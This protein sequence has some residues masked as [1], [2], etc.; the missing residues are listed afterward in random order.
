MLRI[1][2]S[3][4]HRS[5]TSLVNPP[6]FPS[7]ALITGLNG[8][9]KSHLFEAME[10]GFVTCSIDGNNIPISKIRRFNWESLH[11]GQNAP[12]DPFHR[13][14]LFSS[15]WTQLQEFRKQN[16][17]ALRQAWTQ[18]GR[19]HNCLSVEALFRRSGES[20]LFENTD[21]RRVLD[22][23]SNET[24]TQL[25]QYTTNNLPWVNRLEPQALDGPGSEKLAV[26]SQTE[27]LGWAQQPNTALDPFK[28][29]LNAIF[30]T[31]RRLQRDNYA[32]QRDPSPTRPPLEDVD[33]VQIHGEPPWTVVNR[34]LETSNYPFRFTVPPGEGTV[35]VQIEAVNARGSWTFNDLSSGE[36]ILIAF[37]LA[38]YSIQGTTLRV[39]MPRLI[40]LDEVDAPLHPSMIVETLRAVQALVKEKGAYCLMT[41]H[42]PV[43]IAISE[44]TPIFRVNREEPRIVPT[45]TDEAIQFLTA[46]LPLLTVRSESRRSVWVESEK[47]VSRLERLQANAPAILTGPFAPMYQPVGFTPLGH[48]DEQSAGIHR[49]K[50][51]VRGLRSAGVVNAFGLV[52]RDASVSNADGLVTIGGNERYAVENFLL[53]PLLIALLIV[54]QQPNCA[55]SRSSL[56]LSE[57]RTWGG[58]DFDDQEA[59]QRLADA[60][61]ATVGIPLATSCETLMDIRLQGGTL[62]RLPSLFLEEQGHSWANRLF[63]AL[64]CLNSIGRDA[65][66]LML[67]VIQHVVGEKPGVVSA[68]FFSS[69]LPLYR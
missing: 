5:V 66:V 51:V 28:Q 13:T 7:F 9:G 16:E 4:R 23:V 21:I 37:V 41:T 67:K 14:T 24:R 58:L 18:H 17:D 1:E 54:V 25:R 68:N 63:G 32:N 40:L 3:K 31:Y 43:T 59:L 6:E 20:E 52:D 45:T 62:L 46:G 50:E 35:D 39:D 48:T 53:D 29:E 11:V 22:A 15:H 69:L 57:G 8:A 42:N 64:P 55:V 38:M 19:D 60:V 47:D 44:D 33:F 34:L 61:L 49:V 27:F 12:V 26:M 36:R 65:D 56:G 30:A 10:Q 2:F